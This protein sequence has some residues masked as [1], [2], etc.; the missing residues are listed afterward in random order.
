MR[1]YLFKYCN[2]SLP[3]RRPGGGG[4]GQHPMDK[5]QI[6]PVRPPMDLP[7]RYYHWH[8]RWCTCRCLN[9]CSPTGSLCNDQ[10]FVKRTYYKRPM[11]CLLSSYLA[12]SASLL[13]Y[14]CCV[15]CESRWSQIRRQQK[16]MGLFQIFLYETYENYV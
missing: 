13:G 4:G 3:L 9:W 16:S 14:R 8:V 6:R 11:L 10:H 5:T 1:F 2:F 15:G 12:P 7:D